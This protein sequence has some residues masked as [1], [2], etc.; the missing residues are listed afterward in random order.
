[1]VF[2]SVQAEAMCKECFFS[3]FEKEVHQTIIDSQ[4]FSKGDRIAIGASG[5][6]GMSQILII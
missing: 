3:S 1:L 2:S 5:G 4:L 6:K